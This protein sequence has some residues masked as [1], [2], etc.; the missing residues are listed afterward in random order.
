MVSFTPWL[1]YSQYLCHYV[2]KKQNPNLDID[3]FTLVRRAEA[4]S[5]GRHHLA[6]G[7]VICS[8]L[9]IDSRDQKIQLILTGDITLCEANLEVILLLL[10]EGQKP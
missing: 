8:S 1:L 3:S 6:Q 9:F 4:I 10:L 2:I 7:H 5:Y